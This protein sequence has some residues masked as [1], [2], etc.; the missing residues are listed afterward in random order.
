MKVKN[1]YKMLCVETID[2]EIT[3]LHRSRKELFIELRKVFEE[4][5]IPFII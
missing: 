3:W 2:C 1:K 4:N 5:M